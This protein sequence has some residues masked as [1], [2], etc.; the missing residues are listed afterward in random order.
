M[1][2][3]VHGGPQGAW[4][5]SWSYRWNPQVFAGAGY[6]VV[7]PNPTRFDRLWAEVHR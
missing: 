4:G 1:L 7:M 2:L 3:L 6:V 5:Q